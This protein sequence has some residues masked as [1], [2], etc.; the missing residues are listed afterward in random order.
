MPVLRRGDTGT[1]VAEVRDRLTHLGLI[2]ASGTSEH[3]RFD[4]ELEA[5]VRVFQ[6][7]R[8]LS[9]DGLVGAQTLRRLEE[10]RWT[11]GDRV[12]TFTPG[13][14]IHGEDV[15]QLQQRL[16]ELG[17]TVDRV[18]G[19]FGRITDSAVREF[20][21]NVGLAADGIAGPDVFKALARLARTVAGGRQEHLRELASWDGG[22]RQLALDTS[23]ILIDPSDK[24]RELVGQSLT[25]AQV[26][27]DIANRLEGRLLA[28]GAL[29]VLT[30]S[31][32][33]NQGDERERAKLANEQ[34]IDLVLSLK[35]DSHSNPA[36]AGVA[37]YY[38]GHEFSRS[39]T[40]MRMA[41]LLQE[42]LGARTAL[43]DCGAHPKT[44]DLLRLTRM[45]AVR[46]DIGYR[47]SAHDSGVLADPVERD[48]IAAAMFSAV[49]RLLTPR[50]G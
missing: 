4:S 37:S 12:L 22:A 44:W 21:R 43:R 6:Q 34:G 28:A 47:T 40:G 50:I 25:E 33:A 5:A 26:C 32:D 39:A 42:E 14:L 20:Q 7:S 27:W 13:H 48:R 3:D 2:G 19:I 16:L 31:G 46:T 45:P 49:T 18:D 23:S 17:F 29:V 24:D 35:C 36:A 38:F 1:A 41:E 9:V 30:R 10:A 11:L 8:G 15:A